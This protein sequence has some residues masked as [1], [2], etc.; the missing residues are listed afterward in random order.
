MFYNSVSQNENSKKQLKFHS[1][2]TPSNRTE[3]FLKD[4]N[5]KNKRDFSESSFWNI[6]LS[7]EDLSNP[8]EKGEYLNLSGTCL[9]N[10][11]LVE[12]N[13]SYTN[14]SGTDLRG[15]NLRLANLSYANLSLTHIKLSYPT[16]AQKKNIAVRLNRANLSESNLTGVDLAGAIL[17]QANF[18]NANLT[19]ANLLGTKSRNTNFTNCDLT[20]VELFLTDLGGA[21][22]FQANLTRAKLSFANLAEAD[23]TES[24]LCGTDLRCARI[25]RTVFCG[26]K[27]DDQTQFPDDFNPKKYGLKKVISE[28]HSGEE[29][30]NRNTNFS[31]KKIT[32]VINNEFSQDERKDNNSYQ[33]KLSEKT[34]N[35]ENKNG[36]LE[37]KVKASSSTNTP[38]NQSQLSQ[39][40]LQTN[41][42]QANKIGLKGEFFVNSYLNYLLKKSDLLE[43]KWISQENSISPYDFYTIDSNNCRVLI[44]VKSTNGSFDNLIHISFS[45]LRQMA[46]GDH[47]YNIYRIFEINEAQNCAKLKIAE[48]LK[49][50]AKSI[51][52]VFDGLPHGVLVDSISVEPSKLNFSNQLIALPLM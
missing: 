47:P 48:G 16:E 1:K 41:Q 25:Y 35:Q 22:L 50:F 3:D 9:E 10:A 51:L 24:N 49:D 15:A 29:Y 46:Y 43:F 42:A 11:T 34:K 7:G 30:I 6:N 17:N 39:D 40:E 44:D 20:L 52:K 45:E 38:K 28:N 18:S 31:L 27:Y 14:L 12:T 5:W 32:E 37:K 2:Y 8:N 33:K 23:F 36:I 26:A 13:L 4:F 19:E 21:N